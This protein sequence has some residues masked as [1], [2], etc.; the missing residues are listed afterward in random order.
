VGAYILAAH[1]EL[2]W[3]FLLEATPRPPAPVRGPIFIVGAMG[4]GT[5]LLRLMLDSHERIAIPHETGFMRAYNA[6]QHIPFKW[7]GRGWYERL[8]W[9]REEFDDKLREFFED[10]FERYA[11]EHGKERWGEKTPL[12]TWHIGAIKR[13]FPESVFIGIAR[14]P[15]ASVASIM[16]RFGR[17]LGETVYHYE[18]YNKEILRNADKHRRRMIVLRYEDLVLRTEQVMRELLGWLGEPWSERVLEHHVIQGERD[19][20]R[21]EGQTRAED[22]V[23]PSR[24]AS[25]ASSM[26]PFDRRYI[27]SEIPRLSEFWG[28]SMD[29]P[30]TL[31]PL[32]ADG[33]LL[34]GGREVSARVDAFADLNIRERMP[35]PLAER[36]YSP[37]QLALDEAPEPEPPITALPTVRRGARPLLRR[38]PGPAVRAGRRAMKRI[39]RARGTPA[40]RIT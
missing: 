26:H 37:W 40:T 21:I 32:S 12:H 1:A 5:T 20:D 2:T 24:I 34:F 19:H 10:V 7:T 31:A 38:L 6:M 22:A 3:E 8:G 11:E 16:R 28:Y 15:G 13:L 25:W 35:V 4:S 17:P 18:R 9:P 23:D 33:S 27:A 36:Q 39:E 30:E 14:H 29:E